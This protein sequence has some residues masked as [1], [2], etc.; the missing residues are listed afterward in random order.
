MRKNGCST[1]SRFTIR[2]STGLD[3]D[4]LRELDLSERPTLARTVRPP[5]NIPLYGG[6]PGGFS[7]GFSEGSTDSI[8]GGFPEV[9]GG[10]NFTN[11]GAKNPVAGQKQ[12]TN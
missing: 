6:I 11:S 3:G 2:S 8:P 10:Y 5:A 1:V 7:E 12:G 9:P 4:S